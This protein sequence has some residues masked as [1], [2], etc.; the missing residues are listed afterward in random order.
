MII[1]MRMPPLP[2]KEHPAFNRDRR[3]VP[4]RKID[5][6]RHRLAETPGDAGEEAVKG[7]VDLFGL[8]CRVKKAAVSFG[9]GERRHQERG[10]LPSQQGA[11]G[12]SIGL[13]LSCSLK[14][15]MDLGDAEI[16]CYLLIIT[17]IYR[18][19]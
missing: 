11:P 9:R 12:K 2:G 8:Q 19:L 14:N 5:F 7:V 15:A 18:R 1:D 3:A 13:C 16:T 10:A 17:I 4:Y 6:R